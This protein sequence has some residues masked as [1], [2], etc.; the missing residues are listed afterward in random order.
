[1]LGE[2]LL[3]TVHVR[4]ACPCWWP[5]SLCSTWQL[6]D[7][8][9]GGARGKSF[10]HRVICGDTPFGLWPL[11]QKFYC[12][13]WPYLWK[14]ASLPPAMAR[15]IRMTSLS[16]RPYIYHLDACLCF[17]Y[18]FYMI[19]INATI[20]LPLLALDEVCLPV[21]R[22]STRPK[23]TSDRATSVV[24]LCQFHHH[25]VVVLIFFPTVPAYSLM[26][27]KLCTPH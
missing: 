27:L 24:L 13:I 1:M 6:L 14:T 25:L 11:C 16:W 19:L 26:P 20:G 2:S 22:W 8:T 3:V 15:D 21:A 17:C 23:R 7:D 9:G 10:T 12:F 4:A 18:R 5:C